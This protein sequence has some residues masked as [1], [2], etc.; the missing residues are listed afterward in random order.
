MDPRCPGAGQPESNANSLECIAETPWG[1]LGGT[2]T[3]VGFS[4]ASSDTACLR[5]RFGLLSERRPG[6]HRRALAFQ[7]VPRR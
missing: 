5:A 6:C 1:G 4:A 3:G 7:N 2:T